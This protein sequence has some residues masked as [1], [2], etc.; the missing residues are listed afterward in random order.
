MLTTSDES[1]ATSD[2]SLDDVDS[3]IFF[4]SFFVFLPLSF[5]GEGVEELVEEDVGGGADDDV[6][7]SGFLTS[8][9]FFLPF[10]FFLSD[11]GGILVG[12]L[13]SSCDDEEV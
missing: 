3:L 11:I 7:D 2:E 12:E 10:T 9:V 1:L 4:F 5:T 13:P 8:L 6:E